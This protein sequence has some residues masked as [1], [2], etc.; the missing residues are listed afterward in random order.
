MTPR[1]RSFLLDKKTSYSLVSVDQIIENYKLVGDGSVEFEKAYS[2]FLNE[3]NGSNRANIWLSVINMNDEIKQAESILKVIKSETNNGRF[4]DVVRLYLTILNEINSSSL[5]QELNETIK[6]IKISASPDLYP[7]NNFA[8][9]ILLSEGKNWDWELILKEKAWPLIPIIENAG[10]LEP[11]S[12]NW[13]KYLKNLKENDLNEDNYIKW[14]NN[15]SLKRFV[16][17]K[18]IQETA[19][20]GNKALTILLTARL[21]GDNPLIDFDLNELI[22]IRSS[23]NKI[24]LFNLASKITKEIMISKIINLNV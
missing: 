5:T 14:E 21:I 13:L 19:K 10:M 18:S 12:T 22:I 3:P 24:G 6:K 11:N 23:L 15:F 20:K 1:A 9:I 8:N 7:D 2:N 4:N 16:L 17:T